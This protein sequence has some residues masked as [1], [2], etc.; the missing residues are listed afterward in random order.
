MSARLPVENIPPPAAEARGII[1]RV[2]K[3]F[4]R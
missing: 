1:S 4:D 2:T 3:E